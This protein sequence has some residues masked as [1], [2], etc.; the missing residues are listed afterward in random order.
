MF[1]NQ[2]SDAHQYLTQLM[3]IVVCAALF[4]VVGY[5]VPLFI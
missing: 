3:Y 5:S 2:L 1:T 4:I